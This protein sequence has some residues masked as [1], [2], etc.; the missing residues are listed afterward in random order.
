MEFQ[1]AKRTVKNCPSD[2]V[3]NCSFKSY[4]LRKPSIIA[5]IDKIVP[6][7]DPA[8]PRIDIRIFFVISNLLMPSFR[9]Q[10]L[11]SSGGNTKAIDDP[12]T[13]PTSAMKLSSWG[14]EIASAPVGSIKWIIMKWSS[15]FKLEYWSCDFL[16]ARVIE[17][18]RLCSIYVLLYLNWS[19]QL[20][21][22][23]AL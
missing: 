7:I 10:R 14:I 23:K 20:L 6:R 18:K 1:F 11:W 9:K 5:S 19:C 4:S 17:I 13:A 22:S 21:L 2:L 16:L 3:S 12:E 15:E 8:I